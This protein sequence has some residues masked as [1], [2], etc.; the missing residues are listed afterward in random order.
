[1]VQR[2]WPID[3]AD[4]TLTSGTNALAGTDITSL[5]KNSTVELT[6]ANPGNISLTGYTG[7]RLGISGGQPSGDNHVQFATL[8]HSLQPEPQ[9]VV[10]YSTSGGATRL[11]NTSVPVVSGV[12]QVGQTLTASTGSWSGT[13]RSPTRSWQRCSPGCVEVAGATESTTG[14]GRRSRREPAGCGDGE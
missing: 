8:E 9:L 4:W 7:L 2:N 10:T 13:A 6:L 12:A 3:A 1:M 14:R 11:S 5:S